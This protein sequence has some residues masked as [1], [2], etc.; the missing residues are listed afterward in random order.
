MGS[1]GHL[2]EVREHGVGRRLHQWRINGAQFRHRAMGVRGWVGG[3]HV[4]HA[5]YRFLPATARGLFH[6]PRC[7]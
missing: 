7:A 5:T 2:L 3:G 1:L 4:L 6:P